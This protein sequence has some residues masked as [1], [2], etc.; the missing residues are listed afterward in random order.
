MKMQ[1]SKATRWGG[2]RVLLFAC[3]L[4][5]IIAQPPLKE[6]MGSARII[7]AMEG[8][9]AAILPAPE[10][11]RDVSVGGTADI[12]WQHP[13]TGALWTWHMYGTTPIASE[14]ISPPTVWRVPCTGDFNGDGKADILWQHPT[15]GELWVWFMN[16]STWSAQAQISGSTAWRVVGTGDFNGD[17]KTDILW[18]Q[19]TTGELWVW[20]MNGAVYQGATQ[21]GPP[22]VWKVVGAG[23]IDRDGKPDILWQHPTTR[24]VW[25][26][27]MDG[28]AWS[29]QAQIS[30][31]TAWRVA[32]AE[33]LN[34]DGILDILWQLPSTG[35]LWVW[36]M[37]GSSGSTYVSAAQ[38]GAATEW[39]AIG[40][41]PLGSA[42]SNVGISLESKNQ[43]SNSQISPTIQSYRWEPST[44]RGSSS[45]LS[46]WHD[47]GTNR[48][49]FNESDAHAYTSVWSGSGW[50]APLEHRTPP[51]PSS[52]TVI[53][54][55]NLPVMDTYTYWDSY[56]SKFWLTAVDYSN[57]V[58][59]PWVQQST[60]SV[61]LIWAPMV[62]VMT[63][64]LFSP[65][66][67]YDFPSM[68]VSGNNGRIMVGASQITDSG[69]GQVNTG[70]F[71][72]Y[73]DDGINWEDPVRVGS[74]PG[75]TSRIV[76]SASGFHAF[77]SDTSG[78]NTCLYNSNNRN[79]GA[80][81]VLTHWQSADGITWTQQP[82]IATYG[83]P[84]LNGQNT[85]I[86]NPQ[87]VIAYAITPD[88][89]AA[90]QGDSPNYL[91][92][93]VAFPVNING[94]NAI[95]VSTEFG[96]GSLVYHDYDLFNHGIT[97]SSSG[98]WYLTYQT[99]R[100]GPSSRFLQQGVLY[101]LPGPVAPY[102][103]AVVNSNWDIDPS[104]WFY[105]Y[106]G[107]NRC[108]LAPSS[109]IACYS[110]GDWFRPAMDISTEVTVPMILGS[111]NLNDLSQAFLIDPP[112]SPLAVFRPTIENLLGARMS[113][114]ELYLPQ[115]I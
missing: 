10:R 84:A 73:S 45:W 6:Q 32:G 26:W 50:S 38:L 74:S 93:V 19:P 44:A 35:E 80:C 1:L 67:L 48:G 29:G 4:L 60:D 113:Q 72:S 111:T 23:D 31:A 49:S 36:F 89:V 53:F 25:V 62:R 40:T 78:N 7:K 77:I 68:A 58:N 71:T 90:K 21:I 114:D 65:V 37:G 56:R 85:P 109:S 76:W 43:V 54:G 11:G 14:S 115:V 105:Y 39:T 61:G 51:M 57:F 52:P 15:T 63:A 41:R 64:S 13:T 91:G 47:I 81:A 46:S 42:I 8:P 88:A 27:F 108:D 103:G 2:S 92:W 100:D 70:Y 59:S 69:S 24:E 104:T 9:S 20:F 95:I 28:A 3:S 75:G 110:S 94:K 87:G 112:A 12:L 17:G 107:N 16:G 22:T 97:T 106:A 30:G 98:D 79:S 102:K 99:Y 5:Q 55:W 101:R 83:V 82:N 33:D 18:Q 66:I 34:G 86:S 96:G